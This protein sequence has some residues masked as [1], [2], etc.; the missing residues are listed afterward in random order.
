MRLILVAPC[1]AFALAAQSGCGT[2]DRTVVVAPPRGVTNLQ[3]RGGSIDDAGH[4][5]L[6]AADRQRVRLEAIHDYSSDPVTREALTWEIGSLQERID[7]LLDDMAV[8][9][10]LARRT[11]IR[12]DIGALE[13][14]VDRGASAE[15][16]ALRAFEPEPRRGN[17]E[18]MPPSR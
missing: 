8:G 10:P 16:W 11:S 7:V 9:N 4:S 12:S 1:L 6:L 18:T 3:A 2:A 5:A 13:L 17:A 14:E 15:A